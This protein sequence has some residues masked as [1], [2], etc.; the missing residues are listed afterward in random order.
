MLIE[1]DV[2]K[3]DNARYA[4]GDLIAHTNNGLLFLFSSLKLTLAGQTVE[5]VNYP[6]QVTSL[7]GLASYSST[8]H[9]GCGLAQGCYQDISRNAAAANTGF[10]TRHRYLIRS[11]YPNGSFQCAIPM[12]WNLVQ[13]YPR[14]RKPMLS[15]SVIEYSNLKA[16]D[17]MSVLF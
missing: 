1:G 15:L 8:Y 7:L 2:L 6:G 4:D 14:I 12:Q 10:S 3:V 13:M 5:H 11:S 16:M 17:Q 9:K